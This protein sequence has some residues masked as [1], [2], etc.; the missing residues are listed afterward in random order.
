MRYSENKQESQE[1]LR[2]ALPLMVRQLAAFHPLS[3]ALWYEHASGMNPDLSR[4]LEKRLSA[5]TLLT[6]TDVRGLYTQH[7]AARDMKAFEALQARVRT[8]L[9]DTAHSAAGASAETQQLGHSLEKHAQSLAGHFDAGALRAVADSM[10]ADARRLQGVTADLSRT[11][12]DHQ[13]ELNTLTEKLKVAHSEALTDSLTG[14]KNRRGLEQAF[15]QLVSEPGGLGEAALLLADIDHFKDVNDTYGHPL[16]D[17]V[18]RSVAQVL[19]DHIKGRDVAARLGGEE[20][21][22]LLPHT[23]LAGAAALADHIRLAVAAGQI[24]RSSGQSLG[25]VTVSVG[26]A[27][28]RIGETLELLIERADA[29]MYVAKREGR[30]RVRL[31]EASPPG[32][33]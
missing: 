18:I 5:N 29:A 19:R 13:R 10:L 2:R 20:F 16:G 7:I 33:G 28:I 22:V 12:E 23:T 26:V 6:E 1:Y 24:K 3:Y 11:L 25:N 21:A 15:E 14:L 30:N 17:K 31:A 4:V 9:Q 32:D 8:L 27:V